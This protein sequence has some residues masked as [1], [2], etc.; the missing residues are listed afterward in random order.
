MSLAAPLAYRRALVRQSQNT[1]K[2]T[3]LSSPDY[4]APVASAYPPVGMSHE[5]CS[6]TSRALQGPAFA[7]CPSFPSQLLD[8]AVSSHENPVFCHD[9]LDCRS[10]AGPGDAGDASAC[11]ACRSE[12]ETEMPGGSHLLASEP[13]CRRAL[14]V[15]WT[16]VSRLALHHLHVHV[17]DRAPCLAHHLEHFGWAVPSVFFCQSC[18]AP[19]RVCFHGQLLQLL[20]RQSCAPRIQKGHPF[21]YTSYHLPMKSKPLE[22]QA[23]SQ[24][25]MIQA[26]CSGQPTVAG[27]PSGVI[28]PILGFLLLC[29]DSSLGQ[30][31]FLHCNQKPVPE[32]GH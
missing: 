16:C 22:M 30:P 17:R 2:S 13:G 4:H 9:C 28:L 12:T 24:T 19:L 14:S 26:D 1:R 23:A 7:F 6:R 29:L 31:V 25:H 27:S 3:Q 21:R 8:L 18:F 5:H 11:L 32:L 15:A 10:G 20:A